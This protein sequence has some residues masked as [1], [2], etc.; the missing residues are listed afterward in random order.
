MNNPHFPAGG[1]SPRIAPRW[2]RKRF[3][4]PALVLSFAIG[5]TASDGGA[6]G[7]DAP[8]EVKAAALPAPTVTVTEQ[9][10]PDPQPAPTV[11]VRVTETARATVTAAPAGGG[12]TRT[13]GGSSG[14]E[15]SPGSAEVSYGNCSEARAAGAAPVH[16]GE[17][18]YG[19][20]LDRDG[21]GVGCDI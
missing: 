7:H 8:P 20:H 9:A 16:R 3:V 11:T 6:A 12:N 17:P 5:A 13:A 10:A 14:G 4:L 19:R 2:A 21:D 15:G 1:P 18:G